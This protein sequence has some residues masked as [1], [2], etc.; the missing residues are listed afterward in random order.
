MSEKKKGLTRRE[1]L[2]KTGGAATLAGVGA[3]GLMLSPMMA[4]A[5]EAPKKWDESYDVVVI[6]S[7][8]AGLAAAIEARQAGSSVMVM[9]KMAV[10]GGNSIIN[11]GV[12]AAAGSPLQTRAGIKDTPDLLLEDMLKAGLYLNH[13]DLAGKVAEKSNEVVQWTIDFLGTQYQENLVHLGG[14]SVPRS[15]STFNH[16]GSAI[17]L[18]QIAKLKAMGENVKT[19]RFLET[20]IRDKEG[21]IIGIRMQD[22]YRFPK[23][24][25]AV[26]FVQAKK[27]VIL[28]TG[29]FSA[30]LPF[31][32][33]QDPK[34]T[35][36]VDTTNQPGATAEGL[37]EALR[38]G[39]TPVQISWIQLGPWASPDE[40]GFGIGPHFA[41]GAAFPYGVMVDPKTGLRFINELAD[42]K[43]RADAILKTGHPC[44]VL[45]DSQGVAKIAPLLPKQIE[46]GV[47]KKFDTLDALAASYGIP[48]GSLRE[49][50]GNYNGFIKNGEDKE[51]G[52]YLQKDVKPIGQA[53][54]YAMRVWPKVH[55][56]MGGI[57]INT[58]AQPLD[59]DHRPIP[60][61][62]AAGEIAGGVHGAVRL[63]SCAVID[64]LVFGRIAGQNAAA[65]KVR[66]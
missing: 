60:G 12:I 28:A 47:V 38:I 26:R 43:I 17:V 41:A 48:A 19:K 61:L 42:R 46:R 49:T 36:D 53:P 8:F 13:L 21:R 29:G 9:E 66:S 4:R 25:G 51:F 14:H 35:R 55:H 6:G 7:G 57:Q 54:F 62:Y 18:Q 58:Q 1:F 27:A 31:R 39:A 34:L 37:L 44:V 10:P 16:S 59:L 65:E 33:I 52:K 2:R 32:S 30:D 11:G 56:T 63:G 24:G 23:G 40:K 5:D 15:Y 20:F 22:G 45:A 3:G 50:V 64:C